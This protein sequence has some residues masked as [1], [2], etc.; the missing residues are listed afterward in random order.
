MYRKGVPN[1]SQITTRIIEIGY[2]LSPIQDNLLK[3]RIMYMLTTVGTDYVSD[4]IRPTTLKRLSDKP[5][6]SQIR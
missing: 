6:I 1:G 3:V 4:Y 2:E 5:E